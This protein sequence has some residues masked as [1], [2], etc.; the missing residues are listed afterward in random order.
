MRTGGPALTAPTPIPK[1]QQAL[2]I[3]HEE[4]LRYVYTGNIPGEENT[5]CHT[6]GHLLIR[7]SGWTSVRNAVTADGRC[8]ECGAPVM[9]VGMAPEGCKRVF[10]SAS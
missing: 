10:G 2:E 1:P 3:G 5:A 9:G 4:G 8:S 6:C 7:R